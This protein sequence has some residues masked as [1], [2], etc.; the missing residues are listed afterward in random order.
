MKKYQK[1]ILISA[2]WI[3]PLVGVGY[4]FGIGGYALGTSE[5]FLTSQISVESSN[6][7]VLA[8]ALSLSEPRADIP[9]EAFAVSYTHLTLPTI[10]SV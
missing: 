3:I 6:A 5:S 7:R 1:I 9:P 8:M 4:L 10:C 2:F